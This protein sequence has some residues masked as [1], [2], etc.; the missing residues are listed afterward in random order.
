MEPSFSD[1]DFVFIGRWHSWKEQDVVV[2]RDPRD[3][4]RMLLKRIASCGADSY[5]VYGDNEE[6]STDSRS[7][8]P[9]SKGAVIGKVLFHVKQ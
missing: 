7:F 3:K 6:M 1:G 8:G 5:I 9:V 4:N 2:V